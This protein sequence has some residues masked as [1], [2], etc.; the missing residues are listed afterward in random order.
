MINIP[1]KEIDPKCRDMVKFF[2]E[3]GLIT[4]FSCE[5][6]DNICSNSFRIMFA[7][8]VVDKDI[9]NFLSNFDQYPARPHIIGEFQ[10]WMRNH[11]GSILSNWQY[12]ISYSNYEMNQELASADY[13]TMK[14]IEKTT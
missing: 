2:N 13:K 8:C 1:Y 6:H 11:R 14:K 10:K 12:V 4:E 7:D 5:G 3:V 9:N